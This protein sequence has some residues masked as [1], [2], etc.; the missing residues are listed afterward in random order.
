MGRTM[1]VA[2]DGESLTIGRLV[3]VA[4]NKEHVKV[5]HDPGRTKR[6]KK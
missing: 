3:D 1:T 5:V 2:L 6:G 4:R